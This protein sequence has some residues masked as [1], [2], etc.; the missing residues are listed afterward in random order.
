MPTQ[1]SP[2]PRLFAM[3][4]TSASRDY[5]PHALRTFFET[6]PLNESDSFVLINNDD[7]EP[8]PLIPSKTRKFELLNNSTPLGFAAN[9]NQMIDLALKTERDLFFINN[10]VIF[11][12]D[13]LSPLNGNDQAIL[14]PISNREVQYSGSATVVS[15]KHVA[16]NMLLR[17]PMELSEYL[18]S[19]RM[20]QA[21]AE[22]HRK[23]GHGYLSVIVFPFFCVKIPLPIL[24]TVGR[25][26]ESFGRAGGEDYDYALR[27][28]LA[29]FQV[30][31]AL[32]SYLLHFWGKSTWTAKESSSSSSTNAPS[33]DTSFLQKFEAKW[34]S[35][36]YRLILQENT[37]EINE[38]PELLKLR[39]S[40]D[41]SSL[42]ARMMKQPQTP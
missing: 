23:T 3:V 42:I 29:G 41:I 5:T 33:Y 34:G 22:A 38:N 40:G 31:L 18:E 7:P 1:S 14:A 28:W 6:T 10:D 21:I 25:F 20:F 19:P 39:D 15:S 36:L 30:K 11:S 37:D 27:A 4:T 8:K 17:A 35:S 13:W 9:A 24:K 2:R 12:D 26:D 32:G 16:T